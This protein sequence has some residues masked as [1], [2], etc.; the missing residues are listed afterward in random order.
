[1]NT[2]S[3]IIICK[4]ESAMIEECLQSVQWADEI[5]L[6]DSG[7]SDDTLAIAR[8]YTQKIYQHSDWQGFGMQKNRALSYATSDW[9]L[10]IDADE[11]I[12]DSL[13]SEIQQILSNPTHSVYQIPRRSWFLGKEIRHSGWNP[14]FVARLFKRGAAIFSNDLVHE[15]LLYTEDSGFCASSLI[16][17]SY[18]DLDQ[19]IS[20]MN[21]YSTAGAENKHQQHQTGNLS[22]AVLHGLAGFIKTYLIKKGFLDGKE[23]FILAVANAQGS[24]YRY[25]KLYYMSDSNRE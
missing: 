8:G 7:S 17:Y 3:V 23:G 14:D 22:K 9:V 18:Q 15:R 2:L 10:S 16:H 19:V 21:L 24:Y 6:V 13:K 12:T 11:R 20:K 5:I 1:M 4:N 25:L